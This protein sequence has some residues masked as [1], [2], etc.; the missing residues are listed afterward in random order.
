MHTLH[1]GANRNAL[2]YIHQRSTHTL[3]CLP[4]HPAQHCSCAPLCKVSLDGTQCPVFPRT[5]C[6][7]RWLSEATTEPTALPPALT[8]PAAQK[9]DGE[10]LNK[11]IKAGSNN[12][13]LQMPRQIVLQDNLNPRCNWV[14]HC[15]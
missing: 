7:G 6:L 14:N 11:K 1:C 4:T 3:C 9:D 2:I 13:I 5:Q 12:R 8:L 15:S 10:R